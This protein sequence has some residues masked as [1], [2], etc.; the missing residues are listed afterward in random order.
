[1]QTLLERPATGA[2]PDVRERRGRSNYLKGLSAEEVVCLYYE[3]LGCQL[4]SR[5]W[6]G[7]GAE[8]DLIFRDGDLLIFV[9]VK[10]ARSFDAAAQRVGWPQVRRIM[11]AAETYAGIGGETEHTELR[12]DMA[13]VDSIGAVKVVE[14][15]S[16]AA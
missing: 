7:A 2:A 3:A 12:I 8:V 1:M 10:A 15:L 4:S 14:N 16:M 6:R 9:E 13:L 11:R 5:R